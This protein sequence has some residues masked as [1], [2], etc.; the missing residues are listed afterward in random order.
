MIREQARAML[1]RAV[2]AIKENEANAVD[3]FNKGQG[4]FK[5][6]DLYRAVRQCLK[7]HHNGVSDQQRCTA[8]DFPPG[9]K[10]MITATEREVSEITYPWSR[11]GLDQAA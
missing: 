6:R 3:M 5:D 7:W 1:E 2:A 10:G 8:K 9:Q 4:G 11:P